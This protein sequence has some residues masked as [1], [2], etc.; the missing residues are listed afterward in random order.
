[1]FL[2]H[3]SLFYAVEP[4]LFY[5]VS[6]H[7]YVFLQELDTYLTQ[8]V[9]APRGGHCSAHRVMPEVATKQYL[10]IDTVT[11]HGRSTVLDV[12][13]HSTRGG[14]RAGGT[15]LCGEVSGR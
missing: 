7:L 13:Q 14:P 11:S 12:S 8:R 2:D 15:C 6:Q 3:K 9:L 10:C 5:G 1:M 4:F